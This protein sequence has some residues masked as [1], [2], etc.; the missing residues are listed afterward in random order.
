MPDIYHPSENS[1][2]VA[3]ETIFTKIVNLNDSDVVVDVGS[4][5]GNVIEWIYNNTSANKIIGYEVSIETFNISV[6]RVSKNARL[7]II[8]Q[9]IFENFPYNA[10]IFYLYNPFSSFYVNKFADNILKLKHKCLIIYYNP[11]FLHI[12]KDR[13]EFIINEFEVMDGIPWVAI[14]EVSSK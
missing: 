7:E 5:E 10:N 14:I 9:D 4:G 2:D 1:D 12:F 11:V 13:C 6:K 3:I 8:N